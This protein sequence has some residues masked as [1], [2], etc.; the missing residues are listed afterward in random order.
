MGICCYAEAVT[1]ADFG[2]TAGPGP[3]PA[4]NATP[5]GLDRAWPGTHYLI[6]GTA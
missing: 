3:W 2:H 5:V 1:A 4:N 6:T